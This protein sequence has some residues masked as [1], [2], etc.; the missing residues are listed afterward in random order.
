MDDLNRVIGEHRDNKLVIIGDM[1]L[2]TQVPSV[3]HRIKTSILDP[4]DL[5]Q[6]QTGP[7]TK[8]GS[9]IDHVYTNIADAM[10]CVVPTYYSDHDLI[11]VNTM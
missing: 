9:T 8:M 10:A 3:A 6:L 4:N 1:N 7:T 2:N 11:R 5:K